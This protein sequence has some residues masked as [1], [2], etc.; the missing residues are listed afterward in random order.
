MKYLKSVK[1]TSIDLILTDPP[2]NKVKDNEIKNVETK[3]K[4]NKLTFFYKD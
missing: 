4:I 3:K 2:Y 1:D